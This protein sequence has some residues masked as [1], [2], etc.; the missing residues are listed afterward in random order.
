MPRLCRCFLVSDRFC[1]T[2]CAARHCCFARGI[3]TVQLWLQLLPSFANLPASCAAQW[4]F[5]AL[6]SYRIALT[7]CRCQQHTSAQWF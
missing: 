6:D 7:I 3:I 1:S 5:L 4:L 2:S